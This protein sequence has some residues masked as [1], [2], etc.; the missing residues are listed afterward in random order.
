MSSVDK[1]SGVHGSVRDIKEYICYAD[2]IFT[3][4]V[5]NIMRG[6]GKK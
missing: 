6:F 1:F 4:F 3:N 2:S 5:P